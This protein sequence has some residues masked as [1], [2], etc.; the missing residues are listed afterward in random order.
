M[1]LDLF[2]VAGKS[3]IEEVLVLSQLSEGHTDVAFKIIPP[4]TKLFC[5]P[6]VTV[7]SLTAVRPPL[8]L[9][10]FSEAGCLQTALGRLCKKKLSDFFAPASQAQLLQPPSVP[11]DANMA[12]QL[13]CTNPIQPT[14]RIARFWSFQL[15]RCFRTF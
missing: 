15:C 4:Q 3:D 11:V 2:V 1:S 14:N 12:D 5:A 9:F 7:L 8:V 6:H 10:C 13:L